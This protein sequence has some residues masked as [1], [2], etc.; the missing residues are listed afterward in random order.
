MRLLKRGRQIAG[1]LLIAALLFLV[2]VIVGLSLTGRA[3]S[4]NISPSSCTGYWSS[5]ANAFNDDSSR[6]TASTK[7]SLK[8]GIWRNY[9]LLIPS[10]ATIEKVSLRADFF[11][12][13]K[14]GYLDIKVS[15]NGGLTYGPSHIIGGN[16]AE[17][18]YLID[19]TNDRNWSASSL[20]NENL[21]INVNCFKQG[22]G[23]NPLCYLDWLPINV[24]YTPFDFSL[25]ISPSGNSVSQGG[26][27][28]A[29][30]SISSLG[31]ISQTVSLSQ[32]GCPTG[33]I[34]SI[35]SSTGNPPFTSQLLITTSASTST[36][37][38]LI[39]I[40]GSSDGKTRSV[41]FILNVTSSSANETQNTSIPPPTTNT[42]VSCTDTDGGINYYLG[43]EVTSIFSPWPSKDGCGLQNS[44][45]HYITEKYCAANG[46]IATSLYSCPNNCF[47]DQITNAATCVNNSVQCTDTDNGI[48]YAVKGTA[49]KGKVNFVD[50]CVVFQGVSSLYESYCNASGAIIQT[51]VAICPEG[52]GDGVCSGQQS[53]SCT[54]SDGGDNRI[55]NGS[56]Y[57]INPITN[58][59]YRYSDSCLEETYA[60]TQVSEYFCLNG[61]PTNQLFPCYS[62]CKNNACISLAN[63]IRINCTDSD[64]GVNYTVKGIASTGITLGSD[65]CVDPNTLKEAYCYNQTEIKGI[66]YNCTCIDGACSDQK[67]ECTDS[68]GGKNYYV[69]GKTSSPTYYWNMDDYCN[70]KTNLTEGFCTSENKPSAEG[71]ACPNGCS[72]GACI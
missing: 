59:Y 7:G 69:K 20:N 5:C 38:N 51:I 34:C 66:N 1:I 63:R 18:A 62:G 41:G 10:S 21:I 23:K 46:S 6:A 36:G 8:S 16:T 54:D 9:N 65:F 19:I 22:A 45:V 4:S 58:E 42:T 33:A 67:P 50:K 31:G 64:G 29:L 47:V 44:T 49:T 37:E 30:I 68:D 57:G 40:I 48:N 28:T 43:G 17:K 70:D 32:T 60:P 56:V 2:L 15:N 3:I 13:A 72:N 71:Y 52:C 35:G 14:N 12:N 27:I 26:T 55:V 25:S 24:S 61:N 39:T 53:S 11:A